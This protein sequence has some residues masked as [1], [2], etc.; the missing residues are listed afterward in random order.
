[1]REEKNKQNRWKSITNQKNWQKNSK[2]N[3]KLKIFIRKVGGE[4]FFEAD[5]VL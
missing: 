4:I 3:Y 1:M 5:A 2:K